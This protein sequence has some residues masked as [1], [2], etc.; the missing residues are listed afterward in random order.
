MRVSDRISRVEYAIRDIMLHAREYQKTGKDLMYLNIGDPVAFD[1]KTPNHIKSALSDALANDND[2]YTDSEGWISLRNS[3][4]TKENDR[5]GLELT[6]DDVLVTNGVSEGLDMVMGSIVEEGDHVLLPGPYYPPYSSYAKYYGGSISEFEIYDDGTPNIDDIKSKISPKSK[7]ICIIN[8]NNPTGEVFSQKSLKSMVDIAAENDLYVI[9]DEIYDEIVFDG[10]FS[11]IGGVSNDAPV[12]LLNGFSKTYLMTGLRCGYVCMN[13]KSRQL[14][15]LRQNIFKLARVRIASNFPVQIAADAALNGPQDHL[16][17][18]VHKL[19]KR[20]DLVFKR[21]NEI[22]GL[23]CRK[24]KGAFY[25]FPQIDL[26]NKW[27]SDLEFVIELLNSTG[28]LTVHGSGFGDLGKNHF[29]IVYLP[30]EEI[31]EKSMN[32]IEVFMKDN[33]SV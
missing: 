32:K 30:Q 1:F 20:R 31:L 28:V 23:Y 14:D 12:V 21:L 26:G 2:Y 33:Y 13:N 11:G 4:V 29:R 6:S 5:K 7:A 10:Q 8:P 24:P 17:V 9:C 16:P 18:M 25:M 19:K 15:P 27:K 22:K 3:I